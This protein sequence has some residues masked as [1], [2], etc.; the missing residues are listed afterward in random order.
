MT[1]ARS[2]PAELLEVRA[3]E[4]ARLARV[5]RGGD[6]DRSAT[7]RALLR[8][9]VGAWTG[10]GADRVVI[11][12]ACALCG[13][14]DHGKPFVASTPAIPTPPHVSVAHAHDVVVVAVT[15]AGPVGVDVEP[16][17]AARFEGFEAVALSDVERATPGV[18]EPAAWIR[19]WVRKEAV[20]KATGL[21]LAVDPRC[22]VVSAPHEP[23]RV[24]QPPAA[25]DAAH[26]QLADVAIRPG[27]I[28]SVAVR[29]G[30][31]GSLEV[32]VTDLDRLAL[33]SGGSS[34]R[35]SHPSNR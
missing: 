17:G 11:R 33:I 3:A 29:T 23:P 35:N 25:D 27:V 4:V 1:W 15:A 31:S 28:C 14:T 22:V 34:V 24:I 30:P 6:R 20:L 26:W 18:R 9:A 12:S 19:T 21:G 32:Q 8:V 7:A 5:S 2:V 13:A 10:T 16:A